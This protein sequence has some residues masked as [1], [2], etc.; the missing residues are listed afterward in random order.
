MQL[1]KNLNQ[2]R[3][4]P[5]FVTLGAGSVGRGI[6]RVTHRYVAEN[7]CMVTINKESKAGFGGGEDKISGRFVGYRSY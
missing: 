6:S 7:R 5:S 2:H 4:R 3:L 1:R